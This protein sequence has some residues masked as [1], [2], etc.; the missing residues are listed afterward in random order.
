MREDRDLAQINVAKIRVDGNIAGAIF[1]VGSVAVCLV[2]IP[3]LG[4]L[5]LAA[6]VVGAGVALALRLMR[7]E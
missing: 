6:V 4:Y 7:G 3:A 5:A 1:A 2:G